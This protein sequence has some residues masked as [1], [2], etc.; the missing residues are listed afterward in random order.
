M[1]T[2]VLT[3]SERLNREPHIVFSEIREETYR[4]SYPHF[5]QA[6]DVDDIIQNV[7]LHISASIDAQNLTVPKLV[8]IYVGKHRQQRSRERDRRVEFP[9]EV[10]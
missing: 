9:P 7:C 2:P 8:A 1:D 10:L 4:Q 6:A 3:L 5:I